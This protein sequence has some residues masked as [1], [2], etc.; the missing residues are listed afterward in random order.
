[1]K[2]RYTRMKST[3]GIKPPPKEPPQL[4]EQC[5]RNGVMCIYRRQLS[6]T[7]KDTI[8]HYMIDK[9]ASRNCP[10]GAECTHF[11]PGVEEVP[12]LF[13]AR[14]YYLRKLNHMMQGDFACKIGMS[15]C[16]VSAWENGRRQPL[17]DSVR[18]ICEEFNVSA[19]WLLGL[20]S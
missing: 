10:A 17:H 6:S 8:C 15:Q 13:S 3:D 19:D 2:R 14:L 11:K 20:I 7:C 1:M 4:G 18:R 5:M 9:G 16:Q 12:P